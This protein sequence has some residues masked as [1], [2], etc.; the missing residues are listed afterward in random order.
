[1]VET[2]KAVNVK[3]M[4]KI[5]QVDLECLRRLVIYRQF[6]VV[7]GCW[8]CNLLVE[9]MATTILATNIRIDVDTDSSVKNHK[10]QFL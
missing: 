8:R 4:P 3:K 6:K 2:P 10:G 7:Y 1:M 9:T 5:G